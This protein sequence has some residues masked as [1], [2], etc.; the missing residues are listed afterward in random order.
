MAGKI[1]GT[2]GMSRDNGKE[3]HPSAFHVHYETRSVEKLTSGGGC[4]QALL[5]QTKLQSVTFFGDHTHLYD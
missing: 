1:M 4:Q 3:I 2:V 5:P